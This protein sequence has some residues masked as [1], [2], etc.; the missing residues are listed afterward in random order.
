MSHL[1]LK[2][3]QILTNV[4]G[5]ELSDPKYRPVLCEGPEKLGAHSSCCTR[6]D[7]R[8]ESG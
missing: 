8:K 2:G 7:L 1:K 3:V 6:T 5:E 4:D